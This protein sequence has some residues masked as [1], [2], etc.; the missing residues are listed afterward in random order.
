MDL[1][2]VELRQLR[3]FL[4]VAETGHVGRAAERLGIAQPPLSQQIQRLEARVGYPLFKRHAKGVDLTPAGRELLPVARAALDLVAHGLDAARRKGRGEAGRLRVGMA[5]SLAASFLPP[6]VR[7]FRA[8]HPGVVLDIRE[9]TTDPQ[10]D[11]LRD[12]LID[13]GVGRD[14]TPS[15]GIT[16][17]TIAREPLVAVLP[18]G[19]R[20]TEVPTGL[21]GETFA[22]FPASA[23]AAFHDRILGVCR[24]AGFTPRVG[25]EATEWPT[26]IAFVAAGLAV[27]I[28]PKS[29]PL[30]GV[31]RRELPGGADTAVTV[32]RRQADADP[33]VEAF[34][35]IALTSR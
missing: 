16:V 14:A 26:L 2:E 15:P 30:A 21:A 6:M 8:A 1:P 29:V 17:R 12:G 18:R 13:V 11:A 5:A 10:A 33:I 27:T 24:A 31:E 4:V 34:C 7:A 25:H 23:G 22:L 28:A 3:V 9:M 20:I 19:S 35:G 32:S